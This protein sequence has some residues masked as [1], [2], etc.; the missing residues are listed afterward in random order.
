[1]IIITNIQKRV[2]SSE[3]VNS[4]SINSLLGPSATSAKRMAPSN[5]A[6]PPAKDSKETKAA[7]SAS[8]EKSNEAIKKVNAAIMLEE[9]DEFEDFPADVRGRSNKDT[10][11]G[12]YMGRR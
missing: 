4:L 6:S 3:A 9:D 5:K 1:M 10:S 12:R 11:M 7:T 8:E 2:L